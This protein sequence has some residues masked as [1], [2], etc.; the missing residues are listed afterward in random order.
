MKRSASAA[1]LPNAV[2]QAARSAAQNR[3]GDFCGAAETSFL[4]SLS[5]LVS[6]KIKMAGKHYF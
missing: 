4:H 6:E 5:K 1:P 3:L 2:R